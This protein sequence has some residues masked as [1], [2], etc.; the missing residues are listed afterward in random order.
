MPVAEIITIGTELLLGEIQDTNTQ[1][2]AR[3]LRDAGVDLYR[4]MTVGD[5]LTRIA[6]AIQEAMQRSDIILTTG[7]LG[8]TVDDPTRQAI[9]MALGTETEFRPDLWD[10]IQ[11]R[12]QRYNRRATENN[13]RQAYVPK[14]AIAIENP[15]GTA[16]AFIVETDRQAII[17]LPGVPREM[18][19]LT[20]HSVLPYLRQ[21]Y[22]LRGTIKA[23]VLHA[24]S[25]GESQVDELIGDLETRENPTIGLLAHAG[26]VDIRVAAKA[27]SV[28]EADRLIEEQV[29]EIRQRLG[30]AIFGIN[31]ETLLGV[32][33]QGLSQAGWSLA[34]VESGLGGLLLQQFG[35]SESLFKGGEIIPD[36]DNQAAL[37]AKTQ[38]FNATR[39]ADVALGVSLH[40]GKE[41]QELWL[42]LITPKEVLEQ[43]RSYGGPP[44]MAPQW[45]VNN[46]LD[47][48]R[49]HI[50][51]R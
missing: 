34:I 29:K 32:T 50:H 6:Q 3:T 35:T 38:A 7:G 45:A 41:K 17:S 39:Q 22:N 26:Q 48:I 42:A 18:E 47:F 23:C 12:F 49:K 21:R 43:Y 10:Q 14:G 20:Q 16:P 1:Y 37:T 51:D 19:F 15:V 40:P 8:P 44:Q 5:N 4:T 36:I 46:S 2:L 27:E 13:R 33:L 30:E 9:A 25:I 31:E 11:A 24:A 28:E